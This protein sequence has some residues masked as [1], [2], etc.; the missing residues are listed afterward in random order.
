MDISAKDFTQLFFD[1]WY[2][3]NGLPLE[4]ILDRD[5]LFVSCVWKTLT[6]ITRVKLGMSMA[7]HLETDGASECM[8]E[9]VNQC[10]GYRIPRDQK[11]RVQA[12][13]WI[14]FTIKHTINKLT[15][16]FPF[17]LQTGQS[18]RLIPLITMVDWKMENMDTIR[19]IKQ[20]HVD[21]VEAKDNLMLAKVFQSD[22]VNKK[23]GP[24]EVY[25]VKKLAMLSMANRR[26]GM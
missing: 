14:H 24:E 5:K 25:K 9:T 23:I 16:F 26:K 12:L 21:V 7:F 3:K 19:L 10:L 4:F 20:I 18:P 13:P 15:R 6:K 8:N 17:Q 2:C 22:Q 11:G 1:Q